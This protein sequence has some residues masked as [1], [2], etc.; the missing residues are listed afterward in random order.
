M[1]RKLMQV[2]SLAL[3]ALL[4]I[5]VA[6]FGFSYLTHLRDDQRVPLSGQNVPLIKR[7]QLVGSA[8]AHQELALSVGL[9]LRNQAQLT[10]LL[11]DMYNPH[12]T[13]Y[14]HFLT[15]QQFSAE[16]SPT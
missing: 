16:F 10:A 7:A 8:S 2:G 5:G 9:Q 13:L 6:L 14:H 1:S 4:V 12:S 15:P 11:H 3:V